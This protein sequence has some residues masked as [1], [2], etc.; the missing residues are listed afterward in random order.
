MHLA[1]DLISIFSACF[2]LF[3]FSKKVQVLQKLGSW[4]V[5]RRVVMDQAIKQGFTLITEAFRVAHDDQINRPYNVSH[6]STHFAI[7]WKRKYA[8]KIF[9][10]KPF[11]SFY[12]SLFLPLYLSLSLFLHLPLFQ[13]EKLSYKT[14]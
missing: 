1:N 4:L 13:N 2:F 10:T 6:S 7:L 9:L 12:M 8:A 14:K 5:Q 3:L 11:S